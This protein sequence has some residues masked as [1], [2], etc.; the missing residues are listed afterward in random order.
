[1][2]KLFKLILLFVLGLFVTLLASP[3]VKGFGDTTYEHIITT[4]GEDPATSVHVNWHSEKLNTYLE[5]TLASDTAYANA[6]NVTPETH[7][8]SLPNEETINGVTYSHEGFN[9]QY[10]F[11]NRVVIE[12]L[13]PNTEYRYRIGKDGDMSAD[14]TF[15]TA[16]GDNSNY[17]F[18]AVTDPQ[19]YSDATAAHY[20]DILGRAYQ[21]EPDFRFNVL[22]GDIVDRGGKVSQWDMLFKLSNIKKTILAPGVGNH[23]YYDASSTPKTYNNTY[24][25]EHFNTPQ[26]GAEGVKGSSYYFKYNNVLFIALDTEA[27][28]T[29]AVQKEWFKQVVTSNYAQYIVVFMHRSFYGSIYANVSPGLQATWQPLFD[30]CG[31]DL[32][33]T[34]HDHTYMRSHKV[35][36]GQVVSSDHKGGTV[37]MTLGSAG[38]KFYQYTNTYAA[39]HAK[40]IASTTTGTLFTVKSDGL[41]LKTFNKAGDILD[42]ATILPNRSQFT[43]HFDQES[44]LS[45][46][47]ITRNK[48]D[49]TKANLSFNTSYYGN[50]GHVKVEDKTGRVYLDTV[51]KDEAMTSFLF[52]GLQLDDVKDFVVKFKK[53]DGT[54]ITK[55]IHFINSLYYGRIYDLRFS[56]Q[57]ERNYSIIFREELDGNVLDKYEIYFDDACQAEYPVGTRRINIT[58]VPADVREIILKLKAADGTILDEYYFD[59]ALPVALSV[60]DESYDVNVGKTI[61]IEVSQ[62]PNHGHELIVKSESDNYSYEIVGNV[63]K[64]TGINVA[65]ENVTV[66]LVDDDAEVTFALYIL[67]A[68]PGELLDFEVIRNYKNIDVSFTEDINPELVKEYKVYFNDALKTTL[69]KGANSYSFQEAKAGTVKVEIIDKDNNVVKS[70]TSQVGKFTELSL[71]PAT[72]DIYKGDEIEVVI[73]SHTDN[74][75]VEGLSGL[76]ISAITNKKFTVKGLAYGNYEVKVKNLDTNEIATLTLKVKPKTINVVI[77][78]LEGKETIT[79]NE[80]VNLVVEVY[81]DGELA[82]LKPGDVVFSSNNQSV[83]TIS[84]TGVIEALQAGD[85]KISVQYGDITKTYNLE[86]LKKKGCN[87]QAIALVALL[88]FAFLGFR[89]REDYFEE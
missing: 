65:T 24:F 59:V 18:L 34:G 87:S 51:L 11:V 4:V 19:Y 9:R 13:T 58:S 40:V 57:G 73:T 64:I 81:L 33:L 12:N 31:V 39:Y 5:Y 22:S 45:S 36:Q 6:T 10:Y 29:A 37:Y 88:P 14:Y 69:Q 17:T 20:N 28:G 8:W 78:G 52:S 54:V 77:G 83:A 27:S 76:Q 44:F 25:N 68:T 46:V 15:K 89:R 41:Y 48:D 26:N 50:I 75:S 70:Y 23:E 55:D 79:I 53:Y 49:Q 16:E 82:T 2:K 85:V 3:K 66:G 67:D 86:V 32:V 80:K 60:G 7:M 43:S 74:L 42:E 35:Y 30:E 63:L 61:E 38:S 47:S 72:K 71:N 56:D 62:V 84:N 21:L 1:M